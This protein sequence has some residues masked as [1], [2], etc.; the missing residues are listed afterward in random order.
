MA[1]RVVS[2]R[3]AV[4]LRGW[5]FSLVPGNAITPWTWAAAPMHW[6]LTPAG[7]DNAQT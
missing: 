6:R 7:N 5:G 4:Y 2:F 3:V 1:K